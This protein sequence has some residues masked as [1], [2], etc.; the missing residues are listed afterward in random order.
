M[1]VTFFPYL[2]LDFPATELFFCQGT[3]GW[4]VELCIRDTP[5]EEV[6]SKWPGAAVFTKA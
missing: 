3:G 6:L 2:A 5:W 4:L 1:I